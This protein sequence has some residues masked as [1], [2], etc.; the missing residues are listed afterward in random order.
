MIARQIRGRHAV[1]RLLRPVLV[2]QLIYL[3]EGELGGVMLVL[4]V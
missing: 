4:C 2:Q 1:N 3:F